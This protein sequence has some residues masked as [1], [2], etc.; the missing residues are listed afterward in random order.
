[1]KGLKLAGAIATALLVSASASVQTGRTVSAAPHAS[2]PSAAPKSA[3]PIT[4]NGAWT[5][6]HHDDAH[7]GYDTTLPA[8]TGASTGWVRTALDQTI[9]AEP[10]VYNGLV[11]AATLNNTVYALNQTDGSIVWTTHLRAPETTGWTCGNFSSQ[12]IVG[13]PVIDAT[14]GRIYVV[15]LDGTDDLYRLE[16]LN[17]ATGIEELTTIVTTMAA[18][19]FDWTIQQER[20]AL[21][22]RNGY[23]YVPFGGRAGDCGNYHGY[24][25]AVPINGGAVLPPYITPGAGA[26]FWTAGG[27][28]VDDS[29]GKVFETSGNGVGSGCAANGN[30]TPTYENDAVV[31]LSATVAHE[32]AFIPQ[33]WRADWCA[34]DQDLGSASMVLISPTLAF[35]AGKWGTGFLVNPQALG[36]MDGQLYPTPKPAGYVEANVC[37]GNHSDANFGSYAYAAPYV[38]LSCEGNGLVAL[39]VNTS[40]PSF[41][42]CDATCGGPSWNATG[43]SPGPPIVAGGAVWAVDTNGGGLYGFNASTGVQIYHSAGF[44]VTHFTTPSEAGGQVFVGSGNAVRSFNVINGCSSVTLTAAP[45]GSALTGTTVVLSAAASGPACTSPQYRFWIRPAAGS[46]SMVQDYSSTSTYNWTSTT[47]AGGYYLG[48]HARELG[49]TAAFESLTSI[50]YTLISRAC[51]SVA[52]SAA[53]PS[54]SLPGTAVTFTGAAS[55]C[56]SP[57]Y[58]FWILTP[59]SSTWAVAQAYSATATFNWTT[60]GLPSGLYRFSVWARDTSSTGTSCNS[61]GCNDAFVPINYSLTSTACSGLTGS[62]A[63]ASP[64]APG[65]AITFTGV[66]SGCGGTPLYQF[67]M[68]APGSSTWTS[69]QAYSTSATFNWTT[70]G[71]V[72]GLYHFG[73]WVRDT[74][75]TGTMC[76]SLGCKDA[77][78][79]LNYTLTST[80]CTSVTASAAPPSPSAAGTSV[81]FTGNASGCPNPLYEFWILPPGSTTWTVARAYSATASFVWSTAGPLPAGLYHFGIWARDASSSG[82]VCDSLGCKDTF[83]AFTYTLTSTPCTGVTASAAPPTTSP[84]GTAVVF[85]GVASGCGG[86]PQYEFWILTPGSTTWVIAQAYSTSATFNWTT[87]GLPPGLYRFSVWVKDSSSSGGSCNSL[88]C[89]DTFVAI[90]HTLT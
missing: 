48:V 26:G 41:S 20:G 32:D 2:A 83:V 12:G 53:P 16:G 79:A 34:N 35:Q 9:Y 43:F 1:V 36:G 11:Y 13:T 82:A 88:G 22:L 17:L 57:L 37:R 42:N 55:G 31:R 6:Y 25:F 73:I 65:T 40:T 8:A 61:L 49:S 87:T 81:T 46:W 54:P 47:T 21:A 19:G 39:Q 72:G 86:T 15:T 85:T 10:L 24:V 89:N 7:T 62:A 44:G 74:S 90:N 69:V 3:T 23:V 71:L 45:S 58:Q 78:V 56:P 33:D 67:W 4:A 14:G 70:T 63:P 30:G 27:V 18:T 59:G 75:S 84:S 60:T 28:V 29:T 51:T 80:P 5:V 38:Y 52:A 68:L 64:Q 77:F 76:D 50:P 66:A